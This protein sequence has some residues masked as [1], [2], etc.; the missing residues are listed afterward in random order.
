MEQGCRN[1]ELPAGAARYQPLF[2]EL[3][4]RLAKGRVIAAI[5]GGSA[6]GKTT[7]GGLLKEYYG[8]TVFHMDDFF[9]RP[10]QRTPERYAEAGGN[11]DWERFLEEVLKPLSRGVTVSYRKFD[12][13]SMSLAEAE[14]IVPARLVI[15]EGAYSMHPEL[16]AYYDFSVFLDIAPKLQRERILRRNTEEK[17][18]RFFHEWI[19]MERNYF[20]K[21]G[22]K[23][24]CD[25][26]IDIVSDSGRIS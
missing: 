20:E 1:Q 2:D 6:S 11:V 23:K 22:A 19:P 14:Q 3:D 16:A 18:Q 17:A 8:C 12:C 24:R 13:S 7:L 10:E 26:V 9:L 15:V 5:E 4:K 25:M 21:T